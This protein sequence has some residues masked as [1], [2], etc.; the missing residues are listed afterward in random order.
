MSKCL[1]EEDEILCDDSN[2]VPNSST[3][4]V[5]V[6]L[7]NGHPLLIVLKKDATVQD[8]IEKTI[9]KSNALTS[10][11]QKKCKELKE[12]ADR[13]AAEK[14]MTEKKEVAATSPPLDLSEFTDTQKDG[15]PRH[16][17]LDGLTEFL[18]STNMESSHRRVRNSEEVSRSI[19]FD[20]IIGAKAM[21]LLNDTMAYELRME[22]AD[23]ECDMDFPGI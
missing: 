18:E 23:G 19:R 16:D 1:E 3:F 9:R 13:A 20:Q 11:F 4:R 2:Y 7:P 15:S 8:A 22:I 5:K 14:D 6:Y 21:T 17:S 12:E 10:L